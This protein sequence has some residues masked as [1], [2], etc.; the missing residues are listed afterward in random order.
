MATM[1]RS[2][3]TSLRS[4]RSTM[5]R[6]RWPTVNPARLEGRW[7][8]SGQRHD[9][10]D[11]GQRIVVDGQAHRD[12]RDAVRGAH[13]GRQLHPRRA[14]TGRAGPR[15]RQGHR[16]SGDEWRQGRDAQRRAL[17]VDRIEHRARRQRHH[18]GAQQVRMLCDRHD[19]G[20]PF[21][22]THVDVPVRLHRPRHD[23]AAGV[24]RWWPEPRR[25]DAERD[26][27]HLARGEVASAAPVP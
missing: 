23:G 19:D 9:H 6:N 3:V 21:V 26:L 14:A 8:V 7:Q 2:A 22:S 27:Q 15:D 11:T 25:R 5:T 16:S 10:L 24:R 12:H 1:G 17:I 18:P 20:D 13:I 4:L